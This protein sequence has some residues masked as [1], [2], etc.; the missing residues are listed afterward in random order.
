MYILSNESSDPVNN[1]NK[2][3]FEMYILLLR[4]LLSN[5]L[6]DP[7]KNIHKKFYINKFKMTLSKGLWPSLSE[8][9]QKLVK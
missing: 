1:Y 5:F 9:G 6:N 8:S 2:S 3:K 4:S 7:Q